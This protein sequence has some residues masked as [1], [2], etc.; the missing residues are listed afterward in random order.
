[1]YKIIGYQF[2]QF[3]NKLSG[4]TVEYYRVSLATTDAGKGAEGIQAEVVNIGKD[5]FIKNGYATLYQAETDL[6]ILYNK[7][8]K[9][10]RFIPCGSNRG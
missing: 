3:T 4:E 7:Y 1:M 5:K 6:E 8:G 2:I 9:I 10:D